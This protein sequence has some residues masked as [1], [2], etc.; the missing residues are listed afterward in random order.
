MPSSESHATTTPS[1]FASPKCWYNWLLFRDVHGLNISS[2]HGILDG[3]GTGLWDCKASIG[4]SNCPTGAIGSLLD[5]EKG[6][7]A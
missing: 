5:G 6:A 2:S 7:V 1:P 4:K 3:Q